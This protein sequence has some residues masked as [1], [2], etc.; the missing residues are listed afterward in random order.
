[1]PRGDF[2][3]NKM[4]GERNQLTQTLQMSLFIHT[5]N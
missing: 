4:T 1:M 3:K 5:G 2:D